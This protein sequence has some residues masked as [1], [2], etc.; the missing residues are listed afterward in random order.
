MEDAAEMMQRSSAKTLARAEVEWISIHGDKNAPPSSIQDYVSDSFFF[1]T[2]NQAELG[3]REPILI[4]A[5]LALSVVL[6]E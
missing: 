6:S 4:H 5:S 1:A 2:G 3:K